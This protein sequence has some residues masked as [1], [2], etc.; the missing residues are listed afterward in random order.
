[1]KFLKF[2]I[3][4][5][6]VAITGCT[7]YQQSDWFLGGYDEVKLDDNVYQVTF[8][9]NNYTSTERAIDFTLLRSAEITLEQG[10]SHFA[11]IESSAREKQ[12]L[13]YNPGS[14]NVS[15]SY[16]VS[17]KP[18]TSNTIMVF[19]MKPTEFFSYSAQQVV[20]S[21]KAKYGIK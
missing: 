5:G 1:M 13:T 17:S 14:L 21:M 4:S 2:W 12:S 19:P 6:F 15:P 16:G 11:I 8:R 10:M 7:P 9:G 20:E 18:R 3:F